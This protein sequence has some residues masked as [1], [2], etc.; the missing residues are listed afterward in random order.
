[1]RVT[2]SAN[3]SGEIRCKVLPDSL[4]SPIAKREAEPILVY[5]PELQDGIY[6]GPIKSAAGFGEIGIGRKFGGV[7]KQRVREIGTLIDNGPL[8]NL[9]FLTGTLPGSTKWANMSLAAWSAWLVSRLGQ[10]FRDR[11][12]G[13]SWVG[14][15]EYQKRGAL[16]LHVCIR[17]CTA[18]EARLLK[19]C[20][21]TRWLKLLDVVGAKS[22]TDMYARASGGTWN[23]NR[24]KTRT[25]AQ[26]VEKSVARYLSKYLSKSN[27]KRRNR[28]LYPPASW[29]FASENMRQAAKAVRW[30]YTVSNLS[31]GEAHQIFEAVG[32]HIVSASTTCY[33][34]HNRWD[35]RQQGVVGFL[36]AS[37]SGALGRIL[38]L[39][40]RTYTVDMGWQTGNRPAHIHDIRRLLG[41]RLIGGG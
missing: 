37:A 6:R 7:A 40:L 29:W 41:G 35:S 4:K 22:A 25:D 36:P 23:D 8:Q 5:C 27:D 20:W 13:A 16:H 14:V 19:R 12:A 24:R 18:Y 31:L 2:L 34:V 26:S 9:V 38:L 11:F 1:M 33:R 39:R 17:L 3:A 28:S 30:T 10:W 15:W 32:G 21:K